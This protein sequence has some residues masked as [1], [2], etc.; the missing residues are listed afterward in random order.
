MKTYMFLLVA[1]PSFGFTQSPNRTEEHR[2]KTE[3][4]T[5]WEAKDRF[6]EVTQGRFKDKSTYKYDERGKLIEENNYKPCVVS[7]SNAKGNPIRL[8]IHL[9]TMRRGR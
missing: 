7:T 1:L 5:T 3:T 4:I 8:E 9:Q 6:G 2:I